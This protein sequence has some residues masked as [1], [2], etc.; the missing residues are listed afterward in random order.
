MEE[1]LTA[2]S[3][4]GPEHEVQAE[5]LDRQIPTEIAEGVSAS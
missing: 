3:P 1:D 5:A 2:E 4:P